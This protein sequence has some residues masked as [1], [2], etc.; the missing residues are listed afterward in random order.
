MA[1]TGWIALRLFAL[2]WEK[3]LAQF[4]ATWRNLAQ[5]GAEVFLVGLP[6]LA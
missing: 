5:L 6:G 4:A 1:L 2:R 3:F